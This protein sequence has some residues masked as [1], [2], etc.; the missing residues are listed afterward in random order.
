MV[1]RVQVRTNDEGNKLL[2][3]VRRG[4]GS[5]VTWRRAQMVLPSAQATDVAGDRH[6]H[7]HEP[8]GTVALS[9]HS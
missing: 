1:R 9:H 4:S 5:M 3:V 7:V 2:R 8:G 6:G